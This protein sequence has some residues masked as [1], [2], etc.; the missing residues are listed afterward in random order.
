VI[1]LD[2]QGREVWRHI[3][4]TQAAEIEQAVRSVEQQAP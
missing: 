2:R 3:G 4:L 1:I